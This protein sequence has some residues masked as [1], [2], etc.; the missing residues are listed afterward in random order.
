[1]YDKLPTPVLY[2]TTIFFS[3]AGRP[4]KRCRRD[5][6]PIVLSTPASTSVVVTEIKRGQRIHERTRNI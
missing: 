6:Q 2:L 4:W 3:L 5:G 1:M